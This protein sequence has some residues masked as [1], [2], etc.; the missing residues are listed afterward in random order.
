VLSFVDHPPASMELPATTA[1]LKIHVPAG[2]WVEAELDRKIDSRTAAEGDPVNA[3]VGHDVKHN[4]RVAI[5]KGAVLAGRITRLEN[6]GDMFAVEIAFSSIEF[7]GGQGVFSAELKEAG[8]GGGDPL[9]VGPN[10]E[11]WRHSS[12]RGLEDT[13]RRDPAPHTNTFYIPGG[14]VKLPR[15]FR[16]LWW[17][18]PAPARTQADETQA[19]TTT[20]K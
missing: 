17:T 8:T 4:G 15:G 14:G 20:T 1:R 13:R 2:V 3:V 11:R 16:M 18:L 6:W 9:L 10:G 19:R 12:M 7:S 5:P